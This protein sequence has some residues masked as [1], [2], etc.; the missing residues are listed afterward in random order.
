MNAA[1]RS[2]MWL[3]HYATHTIV[4]G[5]CMLAATQ[6]VGLVVPITVV[7]AVAA[8]AA[9]LALAVAAMTSSTYHD[10]H[11]CER[12]IAEAPLAGPD[13]TATAR[14]RQ[15]HTIHAVCDHPTATMVAFLVALLTP[16]AAGLLLH[17]P[18]SVQDVVPVLVSAV[19]AYLGWCAVVHRRLTPWCRY[20]R[21]NNGGGGHWFNPVD[22]TDPRIRAVTPAD[23][24][25]PPREKA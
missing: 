4:A 11:L 2:R 20:C 25:P 17:L 24:S 8:V 15:L 9:E 18:A 19:I 3:G 10:R 12:H 7:A 13:A 1:H 6:L 23:G 21:R 5:T 14:D 22:P 16:G